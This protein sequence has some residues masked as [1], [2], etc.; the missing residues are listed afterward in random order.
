M[1][2]PFTVRGRYMAGTAKLQGRC[3]DS[4]RWLHR[5]MKQPDL[6]ISATDPNLAGLDRSVLVGV[7]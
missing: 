4:V 3:Q 7:N 6:R 2:L 1:L 5:I